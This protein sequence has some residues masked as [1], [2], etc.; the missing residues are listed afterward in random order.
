MLRRTSIIHVDFNY[1][2]IPDTFSWI[3]SIISPVLDQTFVSV[4]GARITKQVTR[5]TNPDS[6]VS[7]MTVTYLSKDSILSK[8]ID[9]LKFSNIRY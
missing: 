5:K 7:E 2:R 1:M 8:W 4:R 9:G 3:Y 6:S